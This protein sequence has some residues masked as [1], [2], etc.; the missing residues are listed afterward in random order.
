IMAGKLSLFKVILLG[1]GGVGNSSLM[2][3][4]VTNKFDAQ[5]FHTIGVEFLNKD[6]EVDGHF[7]T[8]Q[9][10]DTAGLHFESLH[11]PFFMKF[12]FFFLR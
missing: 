12:F 6:L 11:Q 7:V 8:M 5:L 4:Y 2:N 9:I 10:W 3:R 1:D